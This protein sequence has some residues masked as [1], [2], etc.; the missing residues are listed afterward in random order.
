MNDIQEPGNQR[1]APRT[2]PIPILWLMAAVA[3]GGAGL[4]IAAARDD[5]A[6]RSHTLQASSGS[7]ATWVAA[8]PG[9]APPAPA[10]PAA[11][12]AADD[13]RDAP[14]TGP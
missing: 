2:T 11:L 6:S 7:T 8:T 5:E 14:P 3:L 12:A 13:T 9:G 1:P 10:V 4:L